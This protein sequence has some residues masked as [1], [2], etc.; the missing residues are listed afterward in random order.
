MVTSLAGRVS[1]ADTR[2]WPPANAGSMA[3]ARENGHE[4]GR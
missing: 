1:S 2:R 4:G 3:G